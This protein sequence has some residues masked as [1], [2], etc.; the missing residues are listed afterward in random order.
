MPRINKIQYTSFYKSLTGY[1]KA[2]VLAMQNGS[3]LQCTEGR[4]Y[5]TWLLHPNGN[6]TCVR[7]DSVETITSNGGTRY[8]KFD[9]N[10]I[11]LRNN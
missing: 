10:G 7:R 4:H 11:K 1:Q 3:V 5:K 8:F 2:I 9:N 6:K